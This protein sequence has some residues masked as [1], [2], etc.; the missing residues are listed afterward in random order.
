M[1]EALLV[2][3]VEFYRAYSN[4]LAGDGVDSLVVSLQVG[5]DGDQK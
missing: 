5:K 1:L 4:A 3:P 2:L